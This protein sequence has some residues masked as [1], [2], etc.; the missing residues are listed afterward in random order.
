MS[1]CA[2][3]ILYSLTLTFCGVFCFMSVQ[4]IDVPLLK[5]VFNPAQY[6]LGSFCLSACLYEWN[7]LTTEWIFMIFDVGQAPSSFGY[8]HKSRRHTDWRPMWY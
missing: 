1:K 8:A 3:F 2:C 6:L 7:N 4:V 5:H